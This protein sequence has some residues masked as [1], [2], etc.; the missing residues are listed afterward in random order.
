[1]DLPEYGAVNPRNGEVCFSM[2]NNGSRIVANTDAA[3]SRA[4]ADHDG[5]ARSGN[6][7]GHIVRFKQGTGGASAFNWDIFLSGAEEDAGAGVNLSGLTAKN[8]FSSPDG[9]W[10]SEATGIC[11]IQTDDGAYTDVTNC[12]LLAAIPGSVGDGAAVT[13]NNSLG[14]NTGS[15]RTFVGAAL[16]EAKLRRFLVG[17]KGAEITGLAESPDGKTIF[18]NIQHPGKDTLALGMAADFN[19]TSRWPSNAGYGPGQRPRWPPS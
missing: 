7:S 8:D 16:G 12:M 9:L 13:V 2:T 3:N 5:N 14:G 19:H 18:V 6:P 17:P 10:F 1:M 4:C 11:Y 15:K